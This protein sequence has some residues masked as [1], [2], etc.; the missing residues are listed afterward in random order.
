M[1]F[2]FMELGRD[3]Y[4]SVGMLAQNGV[5]VNVDDS[6]RRFL[7]ELRTPICG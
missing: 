7:R 1:L 6:E 4:R 3:P 5:L 2:V